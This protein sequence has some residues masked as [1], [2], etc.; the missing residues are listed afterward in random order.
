MDGLAVE[1]FHERG[2]RQSLV[3]NVYL[4]RVHRVLP[5]MQAAFVSIGLDRDAFLYVQDVIP[6]AVE[7]EA[8]EGSAEEDRPAAARSR[9]DDLLREGQELV[10][11]VTKDPLS[12]KGP[13]VT[14]N[15]SLP[16]RMLVY[17]PRALENGVSRRIE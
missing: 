3:G 1:V 14:A 10:V 16:G 8:E 15:V 12:G 17:L 2:G 4:G 11:Q 13:R 6:R 9:I 5:G 7:E